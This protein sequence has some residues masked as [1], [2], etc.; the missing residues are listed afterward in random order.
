MILDAISKGGVEGGASKTHLMLRARL[1]T[2]D[3]D[4]LIGDLE[5]MH[6]VAKH[7]GIGGYHISPKNVYS[8][9][10][11]APGYLENLR[12]VLK[13]ERFAGFR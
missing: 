6:V 9:T 3:F 4:N 10:E 13:K 7:V 2:V 5:R 1:N 12:Q 11:E 8:L